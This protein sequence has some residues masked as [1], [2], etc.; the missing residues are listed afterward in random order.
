M[1]NEVRIKDIIDS[2][3][4]Y[5]ISMNWDLCLNDS[6]S[7]WYRWICWWYFAKAFWVKNSPS[8]VWLFSDIYDS[9]DKFWKFLEEA[10]KRWASVSSVETVADQSWYWKNNL[11]INKNK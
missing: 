6:W 5:Y 2:D 8:P 4:Y 9:K 1:S 10:I 11:S 7:C 3:G